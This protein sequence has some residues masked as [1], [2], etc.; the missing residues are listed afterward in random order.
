MKKIG[1][2]IKYDGYN[3]SILC[4]DLKEYLMMKKDI[5]TKSLKKGDLVKF[6]SEEVNVN[7]GK[8]LVARF[9]GKKD[10]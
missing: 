1:V 9:V 10:K 7:D 6:D 4:V 3:G 5:L 8:R 2:V